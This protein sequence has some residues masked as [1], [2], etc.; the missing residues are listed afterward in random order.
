MLIY[1][2][3]NCEKHLVV[4]LIGRVNYTYIKSSTK[5]ATKNKEINYK[6]KLSYII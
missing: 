1:N 2:I 4:K 6:K 3:I 5:I